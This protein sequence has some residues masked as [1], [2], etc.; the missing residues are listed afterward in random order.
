MK[1]CE[2]TLLA[3]INYLNDADGYDI[4]EVVEDTIADTKLLKS[5]LFKNMRAPTDECGIY[6]GD[7]E[8][9]DELCNLQDFIDSFSR[10]Y[11]ERFCNVL[12]SF[13]DDD[14]DD[15]LN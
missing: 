1:A 3:V 15:Y 13:I 7:V 11:T 4:E 9:M 8:D 10:K 5:S 14:I 12:K 2:N 6:W